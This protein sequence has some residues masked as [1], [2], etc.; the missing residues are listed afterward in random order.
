[1][2]RARKSPEAH[3]L[4]GT[5]PEYENTPFVHTGTLPRPPKFL[6]PEAKKKFRSAVRQLAERRAV[7]SGDTDLLTIFAQTWERWI[8]AC[9]KV[10]T[11]GA[12][13][14]YERAGADG[15]LHSVEKVNLNVTIVKDCER[16]ILSILAKVGL[17]PKDRDAVKPTVPV[18]K[19]KPEGT[20]EIFL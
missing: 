10:R 9:E 14:V 11:E 2:T 7:T 12:I 4:T 13:K 3:R 17:T 19:K 6:S 5:Q 16:T 20:E 8:A 1:M 18:P 15:H